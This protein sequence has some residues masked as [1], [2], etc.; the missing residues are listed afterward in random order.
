MTKDAL[1]DHRDFG[2]SMALEATMQRAPEPAGYSTESTRH[3]VSNVR[4]IFLSILAALF[5]LA[6]FGLHT[7]WNNHVALGVLYVTVILM[8]SNFCGRSGIIAVAVIC[9]ALT[10]TSFIIA[11]GPHYAP[12]SV[13]RSLVSLL[14]I[15]MTTVMAVR[16]R[17]GTIKFRDQAKLLDLTS[18]AMFVRN[19]DDVITYWNR[20]AEELYGWPREE[21]LGRISPQLTQTRFLIPRDKV[22]AKLLKTGRWEGELVHSKSNGEE[23]L[24]ASRWSLQTDDHGRPVAI[25]ETDTDITA[26]RR[27]QDSLTQAQ[28]E[29]AH[30]A[31]VATLGELTT[32]IA[33][34]VNQPLAGIVTNGEACLRWLERD[35]LQIDEVRD[36]VKR[37]VRDGRRAADVIERLRTLSRKSPPHRTLVRLNELIKDTVSL[38]QREVSGAGVSL[39]LEFAEGIPIVDAD[40]I[41]LQQVLINLIINALQSMAALPDTLPRKLRIATGSHNGGR[42]VLVTVADTGCGIKGVEE[43][44][45]STFFTT[46]QDGIGMG[47]S[48]CRSIIEAYGGRIWAS[49]NESVGTTFQF[50]LPEQGS[51]L[52]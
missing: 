6:I 7:F 25:L 18:D 9:V 49:P 52:A 51:K 21:A 46:K 8:A 13:G 28:T 4:P 10:V 16:M 33:H 30:V 1:S 32:T 43:H 48:I 17:S 5:A 20:G 19:M 37:M 15:A 40:R 39:K 26:S 42:D 50:T 34:E 35:D 47:L 3:P 45:F 2:A 44:L 11:D 41:Q 12:D 29:L 36:A 23:V 24:V 22:F 14:A 27:A 38:L 31:R